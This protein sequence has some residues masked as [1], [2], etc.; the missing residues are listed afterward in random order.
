MVTKNG[1]ILYSA[2]SDWSIFSKKDLSDKNIKDFV[3]KKTAAYLFNAMDIVL[4]AD[5]HFTT[6]PHEIYS[7]FDMVKRICSFSKIDDGLILAVHYS[8]PKII[9]M[10]K[11]LAIGKVFVDKFPYLQ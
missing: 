4:K 2:A 1:K 9:E 6:N 7:G 3:S 10:Q 11:N 5:R 8:A